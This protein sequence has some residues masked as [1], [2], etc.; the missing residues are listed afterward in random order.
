MLA[1]LGRRRLAEIAAAVDRIGGQDVA[2]A[3]DLEPQARF[4]A[5]RLHAVGHAQRHLHQ[6]ALARH[7]RLL[8]LDGEADLAAPHHPDGAVIAIELGAA[9]FRPAPSGSIWRCSARSR[10]H[11]RSSLSG[12]ACLAS[13]SVQPRHRLVG[14]RHKAP[15]CPW[16]PRTCRPCDP[17]PARRTASRA[18]AQAASLVAFFIVFS[19]YCLPPASSAEIVEQQRTRH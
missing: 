19:A 11:P 12:P 7:K 1:V 5:H 18:S 4:V 8:A 2:A 16:A 9:S 6:E 13:T 17:A 14:R 10:S 3:G 15:A